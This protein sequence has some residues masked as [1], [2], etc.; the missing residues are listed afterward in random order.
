MYSYVA[1]QAILDMAQNVVAYELLFR[2]GENNSFPNIDPNQAT[3]NIL[4][5]NHLTLGIEQI[6]GNLS[7]YINFHA[8]A[9]IKNF[10]SFLDPKK[11][12]IEI[13]E[14]IE[15]ND[16]LVCAVKELKNKGYTIALDDYD[17]DDKWQVLF[18]YI[19]IIKVDVLGQSILDLSKSIRKLSRLD[20]ILL[21]EKI[22]T[23]E[24]FAQLK[25]LGFSLFQGYFFA[26]PELL[27]QRAI[28]TA[29]KS[30]ID[31]I[32]ESSK[33]KLDFD[34]ISAT[35]STDPG[36][37]YKLLRFINSPVFG[38]RQEITSLKHA[39]IYIGELELKKFITLL[40]LSDLS[41]DKCPE[42][43]RLSLIRAKFCEQISLERTGEENPPK[44]FLTGILSLIDG[45]LDHDL[46][47][48][49]AM[50]PIHEEI[51]A[52]LRNEQNYLSQYLTLAKLLETGQ[53]RESDRLCQ[54]LALPVEVV[55]NAHQ[56]SIHWADTMLQATVS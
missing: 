51:K 31:L 53:W 28:T 10:P 9:L 15:I 16:A 27:K 47:Q 49:L 26:K 13:L 1:R 45:I 37:T 35:F 19:D 29:K 18:P 33:A 4:E 25:M 30:I 52:A 8:N 55:L 42:M 17:F 24:Q 54:H 5:N 21:A 36:L 6:T 32:A 50:L 48:V 40:A 34:A 3:S 7:A 20:V 56:E 41:K 11:I 39:L 44:A 38:T 14:D 12:V 46:E 43:M 22:E 2:N 23:A